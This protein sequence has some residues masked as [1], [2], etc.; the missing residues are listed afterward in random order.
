MGNA[1]SFGEVNLCYLT[2]LDYSAGDPGR[3]SERDLFLVVI[4]G[5]GPFTVTTDEVVDNVNQAT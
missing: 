5:R 4:I 3:N 1:L 2:I